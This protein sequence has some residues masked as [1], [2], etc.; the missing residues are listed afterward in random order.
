MDQFKS[1]KME[2]LI[3]M[4]NVDIYPNKRGRTPGTTVVVVVAKISDSLIFL[5]SSSSSASLKG[6]IKTKCSVYFADFSFLS[7]VDFT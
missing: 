5:T 2:I 6:Y 7:L 1:L 3:E 4:H